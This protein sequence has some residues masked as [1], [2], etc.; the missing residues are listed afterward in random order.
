MDLEQA[1]QR[2][3]AIDEAVVQKFTERL[4]ILREI[5]I[6][7]D[8]H[9]MPM[10]DT[11][12]DEQIV[13]ALVQVCKDEDE[14]EAVRKFVQSM[15]NVS[16]DYLKSHMQQHIF[17]IGMPGAGKTTVGKALAK[18]LERPFYE[19][20]DVI[21]ERAGKSVQHLIIYEG[22]D[23]FRQ[24]EYEAMKELVKKEPAIIATGGGTV[25][26]PENVQLMRNNGIVVFIN[27]DVTQILDDLDL[28][29]RPLLKESIE[30]IFRLYEERNPLYEEVA[31]IKIGNESNIND[32][33][34]AILNSLP[35]SVK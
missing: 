35:D 20:D 25:I 26:S 16:N 27:R 8:K 14:K 24:E 10:M 28:E 6:I 29:I 5:G 23:H 19:L 15:I 18:E 7:K 4:A 32:T 22:E 13:N 17:L 33:V 11:H 9:H 31:H 1:R 34:H 12:R 30:Y 3:D 2:I 21:Q